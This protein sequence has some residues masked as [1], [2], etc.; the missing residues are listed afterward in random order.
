MTSYSYYQLIVQA[1][2]CTCNCTLVQLWCDE[3]RRRADYLKNLA[4]IYTPDIENHIALAN[5]AKIIQ[6]P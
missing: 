5:R 3:L 4:S 2:N 6:I 1:N